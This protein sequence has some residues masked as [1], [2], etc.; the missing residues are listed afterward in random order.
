MTFRKAVKILK[1]E[2]GIESNIVDHIPALPFPLEV[3]SL[4]TDFHS[5]VEVPFRED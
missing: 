1:A 3:K 5:V 2:V 4:H